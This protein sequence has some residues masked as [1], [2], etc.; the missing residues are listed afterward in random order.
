MKTGRVGVIYI[1]SLYRLSFYIYSLFAYYRI[2]SLG[3][4][5]LIFNFWTPSTPDQI[6]Y[7]TL[8]IA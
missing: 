5:L 4:V 2:L 3:G 7:I 6:N 8:R 1:L